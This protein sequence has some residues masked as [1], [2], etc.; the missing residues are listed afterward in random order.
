MRRTIRAVLAVVAF[1]MLWSSGCV[2][3][4][5]ATQTE[6]APPKPELRLIVASLNLT[7]LNKRIER[8]DIQRLWQ[9]L[10]AEQ[11]EVLA[12]QNLSRYPGVATRV[13]LVNELAKLADWRHAFGETAE[14][15]GRQVGNAV[16]SAYPIRSNANEGYK[17]VRSAVN[18]GSLHAVIDGGVRD[19]LIVSAQL[20]PKA[21]A[22]DQAACVGSIRSARA[23]GRMPMI[24][25]GNLPASAKG[26]TEIDG[27]AAS[28]TRMVFDGN[29]ILQPVS[30]KKLETPL[31]TVVVVVFD[32]YRQPA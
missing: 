26:F 28:M 20:P 18:E 22:P 23:D 12:L 27:A 5:K 14:F 15:S 10:K 9:Q 21:S 17:G 24:V 13:D 8:P 6:I 19:L 7:N 29:G 4:P 32:L 3:T 30:T 11:I 1:A 25:A 2:T 16:L 31:G